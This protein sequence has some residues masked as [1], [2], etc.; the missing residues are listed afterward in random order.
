MSVQGRK[1]AARTPSDFKVFFSGSTDL[2]GQTRMQIHDRNWQVCTSTPP[3]GT[4]FTSE[5][6]VSFGVVE[7]SESCP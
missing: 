7:E 2:T 3:A 5:T 6:D 1:A 4:D